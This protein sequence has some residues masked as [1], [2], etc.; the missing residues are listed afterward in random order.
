M[1][2]FIIIVAIIILTII[3]IFII[4]IVIQIEL[5]R[6]V[7]RRRCYLNLGEIYKKVTA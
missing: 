6:A 5:L 1:I 7:L 4:I 2:T 3:T